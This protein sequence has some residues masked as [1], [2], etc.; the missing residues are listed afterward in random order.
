M[1]LLGNRA[2]VLP[3]AYHR[4]AIDFVGQRKAKR[5]WSF[6]KSHG[7]GA[8]AA[9]KARLWLRLVVVG[10]SAVLLVRLLAPQID[11]ALTEHWTLYRCVGAHLDRLDRQTPHRVMNWCKPID[12]WWMYSAK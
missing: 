6:L 12:R 11:A 7:G 4:P 10:F 9:K 1:N 3:V 5:A 8:H 2:G